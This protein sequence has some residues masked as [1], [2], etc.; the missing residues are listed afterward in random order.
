MMETE[1]QG[2]IMAEIRLVPEEKLTELYEFIHFFRLGLETAKDDSEDI[3]Q[4]AGSW[5]DMTSE[6]FEQ[7][8]DE[9]LKRRR[10]S[11]SRRSRET[12]ID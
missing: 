2:K 10:H 8:S 9:I 1:I 11:I 6:E 3:M 4:Y 12:F 7:F 5:Q